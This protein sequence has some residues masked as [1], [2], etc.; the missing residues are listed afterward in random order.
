M[1]RKIID[2]LKKLVRV[3]GAYFDKAVIGLLIGL[4]LRYQYCII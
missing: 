4:T 1:K 2:R 3:P